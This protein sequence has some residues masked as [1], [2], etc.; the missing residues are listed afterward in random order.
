MLLR[1]MHGSKFAAAG[2]YYHSKDDD[3]YIKRFSNLLDLA[4]VE[5]LDLSTVTSRA[6]S[7]QAPAVPGT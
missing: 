2:T 4:N 3:I 5:R 6:S 1:R 7:P